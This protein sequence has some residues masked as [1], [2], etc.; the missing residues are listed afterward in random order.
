MQFEPQTPLIPY[1]LR[2]PSGLRELVRTVAKASLDHPDGLDALRDAERER[3]YLREKQRYG[4]ARCVETR[5]G[6][7]TMLEAALC[8][9]A[10][11]FRFFPGF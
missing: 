11:F 1:R 2:P 5:S 4:L 8:L 7:Q 3:N 6:E 10:R 9:A